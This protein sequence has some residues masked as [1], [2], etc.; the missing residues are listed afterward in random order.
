MDEVV[1]PSLR[2]G[3]HSNPKS[4]ARPIHLPWNARRSR[5]PLLLAGTAELSP[6]TFCTFRREL[7]SLRRTVSRRGAPRC[8]RVVE[9]RER[10]AADHP[11]GSPSAALRPPAS[12]CRPGR[13]QNAFDGLRPGRLTRSGRTR[14]SVAADHAVG[15]TAVAGFWRSP[16]ENPASV[17][18]SVRAGP[19][20]CSVMGLT[21]R[22][23]PVGAPTVPQRPHRAGRQADGHARRSRKLF[24]SLRPRLAGSDACT[25]ATVSGRLTN[26]ALIT[27]LLWTFGQALG[28]DFDARTREAWRLALAAI[29]AVMQEGAA[30][31]E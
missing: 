5:Q 1:H 22:A 13:L 12:R 27:A 9:R 14:S 2:R 25:P 3:A 31:A 4:G 26:D 16:G 15:P 11:Y 10:T 30:T 17:A 7:S 28:A 23:Q 19:R 21:L 24:E 29:A 18:P 6:P 8:P 20:G